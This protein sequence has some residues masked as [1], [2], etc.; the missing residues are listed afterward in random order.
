MVL[1]L[2]FTAVGG[3]DAG[4]GPLLLPL[5]IAAGGIC[6]SIIG[7]SSSKWMK[8][9]NTKIQHAIDLDIWGCRCNGSR[10]LACLTSMACQR[11]EFAG[12]LPGMLVSQQ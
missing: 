3:G 4:K 12:K 2:G 9:Q 10:C 11:L 7:Y 1:A 5:L 6:M 8:M